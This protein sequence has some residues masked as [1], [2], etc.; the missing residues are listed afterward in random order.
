MASSPSPP[1]G[2]EVEVAS[3]P[4]PPPGVEVEV[5]S[6]GGGGR[7]QPSFLLAPFVL[8]LAS[9]LALAR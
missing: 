7:A 5:A 1:P 9:L 6:S 3:S 2:V 4:S 8:G